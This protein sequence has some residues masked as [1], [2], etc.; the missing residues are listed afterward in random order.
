MK[1]VT[2]VI[3]AIMALL[4]I[5]SVFN[6]VFAMENFWNDIDNKMKEP[7]NGM[8]EVTGL[9]GKILSVGTTVAMFLSIAMLL[10]IGVQ[11]LVQSP[12]GKAEYKSKAIS[13]VVGAILVFSAAGIAKAIYTASRQVAQIGGAQ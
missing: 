7:V 4:T 8:G 11:Y 9:G 1:K 5:L 6:A 13:Y 10:V 2:K 3:W 12:Q